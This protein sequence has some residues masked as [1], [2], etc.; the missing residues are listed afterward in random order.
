MTLFIELPIHCR[1]TY[2]LD[3]KNSIVRLGCLDDTNSNSAILPNQDV[4]VSER[5][6]SSDSMLEPR[7]EDEYFASESDLVTVSF[8]ASSSI[9]RLTILASK[10]KLRCEKNHAERV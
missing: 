1:D 4:A 7:K 2:L 3:S 9:P 5:L 10:R 6:T 8:P